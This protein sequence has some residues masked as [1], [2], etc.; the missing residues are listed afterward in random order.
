MKITTRYRRLPHN[1]LVD[2]RIEVVKGEQAFAISWPVAEDVAQEVS[3]RLAGPDLE[4]TDF[5]Y[6]HPKETAPEAG[7]LVWI[8][9]DFYEGGVTIGY[10]DGAH[11]RMWSGSDDCFV[12]KWAPMVMPGDP[13]APE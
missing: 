1:S 5:S 4:W 13:R 2:F 12:L 9:E 7:V 11:F 6:D 8:V 10:F 3:C